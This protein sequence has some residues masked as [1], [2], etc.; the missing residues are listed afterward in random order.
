MFLIISNADLL[1]CLRLFVM[2][3][4]VH[5]QRPLLSISLLYFC[6]RGTFSFHT[7]KLLEHLFQFHYLNFLL[8]LVTFFSFLLYLE[9]SSLDA[10]FCFV[11]GSYEWTQWWSCHYSC[12]YNFIYPSSTRSVS[13]SSL[14][15]FPHRWLYFYHSQ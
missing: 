12:F 13:C 7:K 5:L 4:L 1:M 8:N 6:E 3:S 9:V 10:F 15:Q 14:V 2:L 11:C